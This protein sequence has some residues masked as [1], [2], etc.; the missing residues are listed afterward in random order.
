[1]NHQ[2]WVGRNLIDDWETRGLLGEVTIVRANKNRTM[3]EA[4]ENI[5]RGLV[6]DAELQIEPQ[7]EPESSWKRTC[8]TFIRNAEEAMK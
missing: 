1:M 4:P 8:M 5:M 3:I 6:F 7:M 2:V